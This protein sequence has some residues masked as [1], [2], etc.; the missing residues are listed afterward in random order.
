MACGQNSVAQNAEV[1]HV[2]HFVLMLL[3]VHNYT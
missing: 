3:Y 2:E 1:F